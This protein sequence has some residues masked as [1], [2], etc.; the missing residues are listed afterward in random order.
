MM[1]PLNDPNG[2]LNNI[3]YI[4]DIFT[5]TIFLLEC[6]SKIIAF[7]FIFNGQRSYLNNPWNL[8]D[9]IVTFLSAIAMYP[10]VNQISI[11][12]MFRVLRLLRLISRT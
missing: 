2:T 8:L 1:T 4:I 5:T 7:G 11:F 10:F 12:K 3:L 6:I 9:F